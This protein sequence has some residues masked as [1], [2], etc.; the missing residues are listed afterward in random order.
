MTFDRY[1]WSEIGR[2]D[3]AARET[4][5]SSMSNVKWRKLI[6]GIEESGLAL[7]VCEWRFLRNDHWFRWSTPRTENTDE[8]G[9]LDHGGFQPFLF[10]EV[11]RARWPRRYDVGR[12]RKLEAWHRTQ[13]LDALEEVLE[14]IGN[15]DYQTDEDALTLFAYR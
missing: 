13:D 5:T 4:L 3:N 9:V 1:H 10:K 2:R 8:T 12:G 7:P 15:F 6:A 14:T 11:E